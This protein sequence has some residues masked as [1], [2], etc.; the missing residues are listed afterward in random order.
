M[1]P[2]LLIV[3]ILGIIEGITEFIPVSS[4]GHLLIAEHL[5]KLSPEDFLRSDLFNVVIQA[6]AVVVVLPLF[7]D[8]LA[9]LAKWREPASQTLIAKIATAF[10]ITCVG[11]LIIDKK[12]IK[13][14]EE[15]TP[16]ALALVIGGLLF[17]AVETFLAGKKGEM[18]ISWKVAVA[19]GLAQ[20]IAAVFPG[21]SRSGS[22]IL[23]ALVLGA[24][25]PVATEFSFLV[26]IPTMLAASA[27]K[28]FKA[29]H[30]PA[31]G[32]P[33][34]E[35]ANLAVAS[36]IAAIVSFIAV[37]WLLRY[38]QSHTFVGFGIY[39]IAVGLVLIVLVATHL[40]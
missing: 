14:P 15:A 30:H 19:M 23:F 34:P 4:T 32:T 7:K 12:G 5:L 36:I 29:L 28:I 20:L 37:K 9:M 6:G 2:H 3:I 38:V 25:R 18:H 17:I 24:A 11:G 22:T 21:A 8:R 1:L 39:R 31:A 16:V 33:P 35:W 40:I 10:F 26:G 13:L 27:L